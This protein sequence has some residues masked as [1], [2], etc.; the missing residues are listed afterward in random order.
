MIILPANEPVLIETKL[1]TLRLVTD[2]PLEPNEAVQTMLR[3]LVETPGFLRL[4]GAI[5]TF[6]CRPLQA[7]L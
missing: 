3:H 6:S 5:A 2:W 7:D 4:G 1:Q